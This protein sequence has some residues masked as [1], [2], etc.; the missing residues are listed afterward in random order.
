MW[1]LAFF[2]FSATGSG[3]DCRWRPYKRKRRSL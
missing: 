1:I 3:V 2:Y